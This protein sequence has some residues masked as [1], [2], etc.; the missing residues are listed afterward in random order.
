MAFTDVNVS[1]ISLEERGRKKRWRHETREEEGRKE[2]WKEGEK[3][4]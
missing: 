2:G 4:I 1:R 3:E